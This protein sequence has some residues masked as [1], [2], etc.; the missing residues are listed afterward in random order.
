MSAVQ[1]FEFQDREGRRHGPRV[2]VPSPTNRPPYRKG[3]ALL[4]EAARARG[5]TFTEH[6]AFHPE[7]GMDKIHVGP[8]ELA[9]IATFPYPPGYWGPPDPPPC[10]DKACPAC[11]GESP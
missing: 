4:V 11:G 1:A 2:E 5:V 8:I 10:Q 3:F 9:C 6:L 7:G